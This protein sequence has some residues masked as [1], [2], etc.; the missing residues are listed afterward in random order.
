MYIAQYAFFINHMCKY[1]NNIYIFL[2]LI[3]NKEI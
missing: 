1:T 2:L 3:Q